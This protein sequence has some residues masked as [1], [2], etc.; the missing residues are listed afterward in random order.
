ML[1]CVKEDEMEER[2]KSLVK[3]ELKKMLPEIMSSMS[4]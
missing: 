3:S 4:G 1:Q 2:T